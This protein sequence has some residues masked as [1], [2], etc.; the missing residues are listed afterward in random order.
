MR[1]VRA[2]YRF[3]TGALVAIWLLI[4]RFSTAAAAQEACPSPVPLSVPPPNLSAPAATL[5]P[6]DVCIPASTPGNPIAFFDD[7]S[8][9]A[10]I[11]LVWPA[12][13]GQRGAPDPNQPIMAIDVPLVFETYKSDWETFQTN[14]TPPSA[15]DSNTSFWTSHPSLSPCPQAKRGDFCLHRYP[16]LATSVWPALGTW[17]PS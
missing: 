10:F 13:S 12:L 6:S 14:G 9:R 15:F 1:N 3:P 16:S 4:C 8:W 17:Y 5:V 7:Y 11:A 2:R